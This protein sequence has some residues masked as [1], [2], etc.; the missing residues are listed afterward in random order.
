MTW[1]GPGWATSRL[2]RLYNAVYFNG[3]IAIHGAPSVPTYP[4]S[5]RTSPLARA[6]RSVSGFSVVS[7]MRLAPCSSKCVSSV[8]ENAAI[9]KRVRYEG[10]SISKEEQEKRLA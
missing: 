10:H 4:A 2:G 7:T 8:M 1:F 3:G 5:S 9:E 6:T